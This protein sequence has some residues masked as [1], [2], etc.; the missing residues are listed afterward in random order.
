MN[1]NIKIKIALLALILI[2]AGTLAWSLPIL[3]E[4]GKHQVAQ[5]SSGLTDQNPPPAV[6]N[7]P[8]NILGWLDNDP[9]KSD[10]N[11]TYVT[12]WAC[13]QNVS[14]PIKLHLYAGQSAGLGGEFVMATDPTNVQQPPN[15]VMNELC[16][17]DGI[18]HRYKFYISDANLE[19]FQGQ[20]LYAHGI[21]LVNVAT[22]PAALL[23]NSGSYK[24]PVV[25][26]TPDV[27]SK[28]IVDDSVRTA[29]DLLNVRSEPNGPTVG[30]QRENSHGLIAAPF[31]SQNGVRAGKYYWWYLNFAS[32]VD[33]W[34]AEPFLVKETPKTGQEY[35][36]VGIHY[37]VVRRTG[38][39]D[40]CGLNAL[41]LGWPGALSMIGTKSLLFGGTY[42]NCYS[43]FEPE[44][45]YVHAPYLID[46]GVDFVF[47]DATNITHNTYAATNPEMRAF[48]AV[49]EG[50]KEYA[51]D[52]DAKR[53]K[54]VP[55][56]ALYMQW[57]STTGS[58]RT[59]AEE[60]AL[61][62]RD[63]QR[64]GPIN[65]AVKDN[66][67][68]YLRLYEEDPEG[69]VTINGK[70]LVMFFIAHPYVS[71]RLANGQLGPV[72][73][74]DDR[75]LP[76]F[77]GA[78]GMIPSAA[79]LANFSKELQFEFDGETRSLF[80]IAE[81][82][83]ME[84]PNPNGPTDLGS[85][86]NQIWPW[87]GDGYTYSEAAWLSLSNKRSD[88][89]KLRSVQV[90]EEMLNANRDKDVYLIYGWN[91][92]SSS[93]DEIRRMATTIE[94]N[95]VTSLIDG[96]PQNNPWYVFNHIRTLMRALKAERGIAET[97]PPSPTQKQVD[98][99]EYRRT[100]T[101]LSTAT[102]KR[103]KEF[104]LWE[105]EEHG[106]ECAYLGDDPNQGLC[107]D[108][109]GGISFRFSETGPLGAPYQYCVKY[110]EPNNYL[111]SNQNLGLSI[112]SKPVDTK[113]CIELGISRVSPKGFLCSPTQTAQPV[114]SSAS[115]STGTS[116]VANV[117]TGFKAFINWFLGR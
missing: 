82:R 24:F 96:S 25:A 60:Q 117:Y 50:F 42:G 87:Y 92:F 46:M 57:Y 17:T 6:G 37:D 10:S 115:K 65:L 81:V 2:A 26:T 14:A 85:I 59:E 104:Q 99:S 83:Y 28:F 30:Q 44:S 90:F 84:V 51:E 27:S 55:M 12:G 62:C 91:G 100:I 1:M 76:I 101:N 38:P 41:G 71:G 23:K 67:R 112:E 69:F 52:K 95:T 70:P 43:S 16:G 40:D 79:Q 74:C 98:L 13:Q 45:A 107:Y 47:T 34:V 63:D 97:Y 109:S 49:Q 21:P 56:F 22:T 33:G 105:K 94:P 114:S 31:T 7:R 15:A 73:R 29:A 19:K 68:E 106:F 89:T 61:F 103:T 35:P 113:Y 36:I 86:S 39:K 48:K 66:V 20:S 4:T 102:S 110:S 64:S 77:L 11:G 75:E 32:G 9:F 54:A 53:L 8:G 116:F 111:C 18:P 5:V 3:M 88:P 58:T 93:G 78:N 80:D 108:T 72:R